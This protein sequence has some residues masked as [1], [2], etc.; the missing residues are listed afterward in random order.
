MREANADS[1]EGDGGRSGV[2]IPDSVRRFCC[3]ELTAD[4]EGVAAELMTVDEHGWPQVAH[5]SAGE[6]FL[7]ERGAFRLA[8]WTTSRSN[9]NLRATRRGTL[10]FTAPEGL[11]EIR[12][13]TRAVCALP[14]SLALDA[15][16]LVPLD[17]RDK[18]A[19]YA[20]IV[21]GIRYR[22]RDTEASVAHWRLVR[23]SLARCHE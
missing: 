12:C 6:F 5:L 4:D 20:E 3:A 23:E 9:A 21:S 11:Y 1:A 15:F 14:G 22:Y 8:L 16:L 2:A 7:D 17:I 19:P 10:I 13:R 18:S